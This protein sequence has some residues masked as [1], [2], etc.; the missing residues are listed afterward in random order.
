VI[1]T[2]KL[3]HYRDFSEELRKAKQVAKYGIRYRT[4][5]SKDVKQ[6]GLK[7]MI[8]NQV[9]RKYVKNKKVKSIKSVKLTIPNQGI[10]VDKQSRKITIPC[11]KLVLDYQ[12]PDF[13]K[14]NQIE[15]GK[16]YAYVSVSIPEI[17]TI[18]VDNYIGVD[19]NTTGHIAVVANPET[20]KIWKL[21]KKG[22]HIHDKYKNIRKFLQKQGKYKK[23]K[24]I[25][26]RES[27]IVKD[28]NHKISK[29]IVEIAIQNNSGVKLEDLTGIRNNNKQKKSFRYALHSWSFYQLQMFIEYK[30]KLRGVKIAYIDPAYTSQSCSICGLIG[31]RNG[32]MFKCSCGHVDHADVN[33]AFNIGRSTKERDL[34]E[35]ITDN[36]KVALS[37]AKPM[38]QYYHLNRT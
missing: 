15:I 29:K 3:K 8:S 30:A 24:Q 21:G 18:S 25:K 23:V 7:S 34:V 27:R 17:E 28:L 6:F 33:A 5:S 1:L 11:L 16:E 12:F 35:G 22:L 9:L 10:K 19:R 20:G 14:I 32:K 13:E 36:P 26:D 31:N 37:S 38:V 4:L 2:Y